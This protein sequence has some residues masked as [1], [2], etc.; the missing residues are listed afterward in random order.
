MQSTG[1][2]SAVGAEA[3]GGGFFATEGGGGG[4]VVQAQAEGGVLGGERE[5]VEVRGRL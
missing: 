1:P 2:G 5:L 4:G 3:A